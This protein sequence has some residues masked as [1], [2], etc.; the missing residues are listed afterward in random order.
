MNSLQR[1]WEGAK[2][3]LRYWIDNFYLRFIVGPSKRPDP[4]DIPVVF[5]HFIKSFGGETSDDL[6]LNVATRATNADYIFRSENIVAEL[7]CLEI[8]PL[9]LK[10]ADLML[11]L[12]TKAGLTGS[13]IIQWSFG[14]IPLPPNGVRILQT[15]FKKL[16]EKI[17]RKANK[18]IASSKAT[19]SLP[20]A[21]G[22]LLIANDNNY[23]FSPLHKYDLISDVMSRHLN[24]SEI[25]AVV[26]FSPN[27][28]MIVPGSL[29]E[30]LVWIPAYAPNP[31]QRLV[32]FIDRLGHEW[33]QH[34]MKNEGAPHLKFS[35]VPFGRN[36]L[37][38]GRNLR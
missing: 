12:L 14:K 13:E 1:R 11:R 35:D 37:G 33:G 34:M 2:L 5:S 31:P 36:T 28:P 7:K 17:A 18:Q 9:D 19:E 29:R 24:S 15:Y 21:L 3:R 6:Y 25:K 38:R 20:S 27:V 10:R 32:D 26:F 16:I 23:L 4:I 22:V 30:W 8:D